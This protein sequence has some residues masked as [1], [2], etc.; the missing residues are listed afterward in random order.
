MDR[1]ATEHSDSDSGDSWTLIENSSTYADDALEVPDHPTESTT[2]EHHD[3]DEDTD[4]ISIITDSEPESSSPCEMNYEHYLLEENLAPE[5]HIPQFM[6]VNSDLHDI[7]NHNESKKEDDDFLGDRGEKHKTYVHRR[8]KRLSTVLNIIML[9]SVITAAGVAIG[10]MWGAKTDCSMQTSPNVNKILSNLYK[11]QEENAYLWNKIKELTALNNYQMNQQKTTL[12]QNK[13]KKIFEEP[14]INNDSKKVTKCVDGKFINDDKLLSKDMDKATHENKFLLDGKIKNTYQEN[15]K[16]LDDEILQQPNQKNLKKLK[17][18]HISKSFKNKNQNKDLNEIID[19]NES[20]QNE[21]KKAEEYLNETEDLSNAA[22]VLNYNVNVKTFNNKKGEDFKPEYRYLNDNNKLFKQPYAFEKDF[23]SNNEDKNENKK[24]QFQKYKRNQGEYGY[25]YDFSNKGKNI[26]N[27]FNTLNE[28]YNL[29]ND[30]KHQRHQNIKKRESNR[31]FKVE[32]KDI[33]LDHISE[34]KLGSEEELLRNTK[35]KKQKKKNL[36]NKNKVL[37]NICQDCDRAKTTE[38]KDLVRNYNEKIQKIVSTDDSNNAFKTENTILKKNNTP[39]DEY[40]TEKDIIGSAKDSNIKKDHKR[41]DNKTLH[42]KN[43]GNTKYEVPKGKYDAAKQNMKSQ[44]R[45]DDQNEDQTCEINTKSL[46]TENLQSELDTKKETL[47]SINDNNIQENSE[48]SITKSKDFDWNETPKNENNSK[49]KTKNNDLINNKNADEEKYYRDD[50]SDED[51]KK[52]NRYI[53][54]KPKEERKKY[55]RQQSHKRVKRRNKY[56]QWEMKGG[57]FKDY[58]DISMS[59]SQENLYNDPNLKGDNTRTR[60]L[61][62]NTNINNIANTADNIN[63]DFKG[64]D[65]NDEV[66]WLDKRAKFRTDARQRL[67]Q[68]SLVKNGVNAAGWYFRRMRK[69]EQSRG[70]GDNTTYRKILKRN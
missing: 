28:E 6:T 60:Q 63:H 59:S 4:G 26:R 65:E 32:M 46:Y 43:K 5:H 41:E 15:K 13:C 51:F 21:K 17:P 58:D 44:N 31:T 3:R 1:S 50:I 24:D 37:K 54:Q 30:F 16:W 68:E 14:L 39:R 27:N 47:T 10:H 12:K 18:Q 52:D 9:G 62:E 61:G 11:L 2:A 22:D 8:N 42:K 33:N 34:D 19:V 38:G 7:K 56:E 25:E 35:D 20:D 55:D 45:D 36:K 69:R 66:N 29:F 70:K 49:K 57:L 23:S 48:K 64:K 67:D 40:D 53:G